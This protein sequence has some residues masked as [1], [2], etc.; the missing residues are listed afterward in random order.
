M[1]LEAPTIIA[2]VVGIVNLLALAFV[3]WQTYL[4]RKSV[5]LSEANLRESQQ[6]RVISNLP[7]TYS[8]MYVQNCL[9]GWMKDLNLLVANEKKLR[10]MVKSSDADIELNTQHWFGQAKGLIQ[11]TF[12]DH[13][14]DWLKEILTTGAQYYYEG[15]CLADT[16]YSSKEKKEFRLGLMQEMICRAKQG[17]THMTEM[18]ALIDQLIP[19]WYLESPASLNDSDFWD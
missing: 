2:I 7:R 1:E 3:G 14:P 8:I 17:V 11:K 13:L 10:Q 15:M 18:L 19:K 12:Y 5:Q 6:A 16:V 4:T 9:E